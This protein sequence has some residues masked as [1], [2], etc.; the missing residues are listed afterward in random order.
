MADRLRRSGFP[1]GDRPVEDM[2]PRRRFL[3]KAGAGVSVGIGVGLAGVGAAALPPGLWPRSSRFDGFDER[4][5]AIR[6]IGREEELQTAFRTRSGI[7]DMAGVNALS[8][9]FRDW[10][11]RDM[12]LLVD[13]RLF[14]LLAT[15]QTLLTVVDDRP[16]VLTLHSGYRTPERNRTIEGAAVH[17]QHILG[18]AADVSAPGVPRK[19]I[20]D[21]AEIAGAHGLGQYRAFTHVDVGPKGRR[22]SRL[23]KS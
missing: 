13:V 8:W 11:D 16:V 6:Q 22:W 5:L 19:R 17:S 12:G 3:Q 21:V 20:V 1:G 2:L 23:T 18:R 7:P 10:R 15:M 9:L 14:D 4:H